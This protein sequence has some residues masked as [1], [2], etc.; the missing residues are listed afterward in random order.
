MHHSRV[1]PL[2][3]HT[4]YQMLY[5]VHRHRQRHEHKQYHFLILLY[6]RSGQIDTYLDVGCFHTSRVAL[7]LEYYDY[8]P[9]SGRVHDMA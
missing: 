1:H 5:N 4:L 8:K 6:N 9:L 2:G 3:L 7:S